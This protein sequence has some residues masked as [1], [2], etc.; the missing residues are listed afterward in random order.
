[1]QVMNKNKICFTSTI[2]YIISRIILWGVL[3]LIICSLV[4]S[5]ITGIIL[6]VVQLI[7]STLIISG[8]IISLIQIIKNLITIKT[9]TGKSRQ[10][11]FIQRV[12]VGANP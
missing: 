12:E 10:I 5:T 6:I 2:S 11:L 4:L 9:M 7:I 3:G 1:M 8:L